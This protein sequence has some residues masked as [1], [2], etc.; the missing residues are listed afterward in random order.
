MNDRNGMSLTLRVKSSCRETTTFLVVYEIA[1]YE[2]SISQIAMCIKLSIN[3]QMTC[4]YCEDGKAKHRQPCYDP[5]HFWFGLKFD[6][7]LDEECGILERP[8]Q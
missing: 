8:K 2:E 6:Y 3:M 4:F 1:L 5:P 7:H